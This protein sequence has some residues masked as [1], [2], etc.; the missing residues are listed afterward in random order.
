MISLQV[1]ILM[2]T[3]TDSD[4]PKFVHHRTLIFLFRAGLPK[5]KVGFKLILQ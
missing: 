3:K 1:Y 4:L 5:M 2:Q